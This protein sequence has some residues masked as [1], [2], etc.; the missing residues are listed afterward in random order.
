MSLAMQKLKEQKRAYFSQ[1]WK[2]LALAGIGGYGG[3]MALRDGIGNAPANERSGG[4][5][6]Y[7][8]LKEL[9]GKSA[10]AQ[11]LVQIGLSCVFFIIFAIGVYYLLR[12]AWRMKSSHTMLGKSIL[13][14][15]KSHEQLADVLKSIDADM[16]HEPLIF[17]KVAIG[18]DWIL[19]AQAMRLS[20]IRGVFWMNAGMEDYILCCVDEANNIWAQELRYQDERDDAMAY[21]QKTLPDIAS[22]DE[23]A[24]MAFIRGLQPS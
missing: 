18:R 22:G 4:A 10:N 7:K 1:L 9:T 2:G 6:L 16:E 14:Q 8:V 12:G 5:L 23:A 20:Q 17:G 24:C 11:R 13:Q 15:A 3:V 19:A 21:L